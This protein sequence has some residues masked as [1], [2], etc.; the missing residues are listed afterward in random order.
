MNR[1]VAVFILIAVF[2]V[3]EITSAVF[4]AHSFSLA[5]DGLHMMADLIGLGIAGIVE[6]TAQ[7]GSEQKRRNR[8]IQ[9]AVMSMSFLLVV[10]L[11]IV[12]FAVYRIFHPNGVESIP[13]LVVALIGLLVNILALRILREESKENLNLK[14]AHRHVWSDTISS[15]SVILGALIIMVTGMNVVDAVLSVFIGLLI[16][17]GALSVLREARM[18]LRNLA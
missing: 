12:V 6:Y 5:S 8:Q 11:F 9:G 3:V 10:A 18:E 2:A 17:W 16:F 14:A 1:L 7:Q 4:I 13:M 15:F